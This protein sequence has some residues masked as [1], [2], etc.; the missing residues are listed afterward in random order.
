MREPESRKKN[1]RTENVDDDDD[2]GGDVS[3]GGGRRRLQVL[4]Q[5]GSPVGRLFAIC[6][7][8][9]YAVVTAV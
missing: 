2:D 1:R 4:E 5:R 9:L 7:I 3:R 6:S 8:S